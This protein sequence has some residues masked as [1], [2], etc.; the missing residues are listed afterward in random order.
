MK[1]L[2][3]IVKNRLGEAVKNIKELDG[4]KFFD[5]ITNSY[6][7]ENYLKLY[8]NGSISYKGCWVNDSEVKIEKRG[9]NE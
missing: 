2:S 6:F 1:L 4:Y 3:G 5:L 8:P 7:N 9:I